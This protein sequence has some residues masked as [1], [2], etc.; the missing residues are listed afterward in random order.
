NVPPT[1]D[2]G[3]PYS[4]VVGADV[5]LDGSASEDSDGSI[6]RWEWNVSPGAFSGTGETLTYT[7]QD[8]GDFTAALVVTDDD[9]ATA[10]A[11]AGISCTEPGPAPT[12]VSVDFRSAAGGSLPRSI[13]EG[14]PLSY[15][16]R[17]ENTSSRPAEDV[18]LTVTIDPDAQDVTATDLE[19]Q[20]N[21]WSGTRARIAPGEAWDVLFSMTVEARADSPHLSL[22]RISAPGDQDDEDDEARIRI[23]VTQD[24]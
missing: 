8:P 22:A 18:S 16:V 2:A 13:E 24:A 3:G 11:S 1:A 21:V 7:C 4:A 10:T 14:S 19:R 9:G 20:A 17:V 23:R 6:V 5:T 12:N 15:R